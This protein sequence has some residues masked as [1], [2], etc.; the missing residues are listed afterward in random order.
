MKGDVFFMNN[1]LFAKIKTSNG[2]MFYV[3][4]T[5]QLGEKIEYLNSCEIVDIAKYDN[6]F[7][8]IKDDYI[9]HDI[10]M[11]E[12]IRNEWLDKVDTTDIICLLNIAGE[13]DMIDQLCIERTE[14][15][16]ASDT[17]SSDPA[18]I[19][20]SKYHID[21]ASKPY[22]VTIDENNYDAKLHR[23]ISDA[24]NINADVANAGVYGGYV[25]NYDNLDNTG[26]CWIYPHAIV[27]D[28]GKV[29]G[30]ALIKAGK[31]CQSIVKDDAVV[32]GD[33]L[34]GSVVS[35][36]ATV[37]IDAT[38]TGHSIVRGNA[39][40]RPGVIIDEG[41]IIGGNAMI[42]SNSDYFAINNIM[43]KGYIHSI[44]M[45]KLAN[46]GCGVSIPEGDYLYSPKNNDVI[47]YDIGAPILDELKSYCLDIYDG[48]FKYR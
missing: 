17:N 3:T 31:V 43:G 38:V 29:S 45:Y 47:G 26:Q 24:P 19:P 21:Y 11:S 44:T 32:W 46:G 23:I 1:N 39:V 22:C 2:D 48:I 28:S 7:S 36:H 25:A 18:G 4:S 35:D 9:H 10:V 13:D 34:D 27:C 5:D 6:I 12:L 33:I 15:E 41:A 16:D 37:H 14:L 40:I 20:V 42:N 30:N 8:M